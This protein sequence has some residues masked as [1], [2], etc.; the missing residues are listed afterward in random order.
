M[1]ADNFDPEYLKIN[2]NGTVPSLSVPWEDKIFTDT[3][4]I[5]EFL[6]RN[7]TAANVPKLIPSDPETKKTMEK[8]VKL[9]HS[10]DL[11]MTIVLLTA[12]DEEELRS[13]PGS[14]PSF[15]SVRQE[16]LQKYS[17]EQ[18][19]NQFYAAKIKE[20]G[21]LNNIFSSG[22]CKEHDD[23]FKETLVKYEKFAEGMAELD[24]TIKLPY[25]AG[26]E[27]TLADIHM[28]PWVS[29]LLM[30]LGTSDPADW[31]IL[32]AHMQKSVPDFRVGNKVKTWW[33]IFRERKSFDKVFKPLR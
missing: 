8:L 24:R 5:L 2:P 22:P 11:D 9:V 23:F 10:M 25:A 19:D 15:V 33:N 28:V 29:H 16:R 6:D 31:S 32:E 27:V 26:K 13:K 1:N 12:R 21:A 14:I 30:S 4:E 7:S 18:P 17:S 20:N 3:T